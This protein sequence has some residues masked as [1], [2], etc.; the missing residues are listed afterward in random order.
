MNIFNIF[1]FWKNSTPPK[2][3][4]GQHNNQ[5]AGNSEIILVAVDHHKRGEL[6]KA[7]TIYREILEDQ[8]DHAD[9][10][11]LLGVLNSQKCR[12][13]QAIKLIKKAIQLN[14]GQA[15]FFNNLGIAYYHQDQLEDAINACEQALKI[16]PHFADANYNLGNAYFK[17]GQV[18]KA[19][20]A[21]QN[22][23]DINPEHVD[24]YFNLGSAC[25]KLGE[26]DIA[27]DAF[28]KVTQLNPNHPEAF[29]NLGS[30]L[31]D[32]GLLEEAETAYNTTIILKPDHIEANF[33]IGNIYLTREQYDKAKSAYKNVLQLDPDHAR[34]YINLGC[35]YQE[36]EEF[37][38][39]KNAFYKAEQLEPDDPEIYNNIGV[40]CIKEGNFKEAEVAIKKALEINPEYCQA[41]EHYSGIKKFTRDD[42]KTINK[43]ESM[44]KQNNLVDDDAIH[45]NFAIAKILDDCKEYDRAFSAYKQGNQ[46]KR[47]KFNIDMK[48]YENNINLI[49]NTYNANF[50]DSIT[51]TGN[52][53]KLPVFIVGMPRSG[54][55]LVE[56]IIASHP[57]ACGAGELD[58]IGKAADTFMNH[59]LNSTYETGS[60]SNL[61]ST[62]LD[63]ITGEYLAIL[64]NYSGDAKRITDKMPGNFL[65]LGFIAFL[66]PNTRII[67]CQRDPYDNCLSIYFQNFDRPHDYSY[68]LSD[69]GHRY[70]YYQGLMQ[71]WHDVLPIPVLDIK[72][73]KLVEDQEK[74]SR[75]IIEYLGLEWD[76]SCLSFQK[77]RRTVLTAST[78]QVRQPIYKTSV[79]RWKNY[80]KYL[81]PLF[82]ALDN[83]V[84]GK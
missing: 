70:R 66:F 40:V 64:K 30:L 36:N 35:V 32:K 34:A 78:W 84:N 50:F 58:Y 65:H 73:E 60:S 42:D 43:I 47:K 10:L 1:N 23:I 8:P 72:Y 11:H 56:Q 38:K 76:D 52:N 4:S 20:T 18:E 57:Q 9:C 61:D 17:L 53:S 7:E 59:L 24:A 3:S 83:D 14:P 82:E 12:Y 5:T 51:V 71:H 2:I 37:E 77:K 45:L 31:E 15:N 62:N 26:N 13:D 25:G 74:E 67:H 27:L 22:A 41:Y 79:K 46:L 29:Y 80:E 69:I 6:E 55:S 63:F 54:T 33:S 16:T 48:A 21:Y 19:K 68:D 44:L 49:K 39:A 28:K 75:R 81:G